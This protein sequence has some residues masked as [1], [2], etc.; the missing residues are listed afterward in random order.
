[1]AAC[2]RDN[3]RPA[4][5]IVTAQS[6][7]EFAAARR[8]FERYAAE[9]AVDLC[10]Q[11]FA[12]EL[13]QLPAMY[14]QPGGC[15]LLARHEVEYVGCVAVRCRD[16]GVCEMKRL[17]VIPDA[18]GCDIGRKLAVSAIEQAVADGYRR[19]VLDTLTTMTAARKL[20]PTLGFREVDAPYQ[21]PL[22]GVTFMALDL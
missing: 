12:S 10:F 22:A 1:V 15:L 7:L 21:N 3:L 11:N 6:G 17:Y 16:A 5:T 9:L 13:E 4:L 20:Y 8:L 18:R 19:M 14:G 2:R